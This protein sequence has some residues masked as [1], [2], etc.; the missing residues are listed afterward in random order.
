MLG[1][2]TTVQ[3]GRLQYSRRSSPCTNHA[4]LVPEFVMFR[5][6]TAFAA[7]SEGYLAVGHRSYA[8]KARSYVTMASLSKFAP[9]SQVARRRGGGHGP[10]LPR[11]AADG[12]PEPEAAG[13]AGQQARGPAQGHGGG[14]AQDRGVGAL[15]PAQGPGGDRPPCGP[16]REPPQGGQ[17]SRGRR[18]RRRHRLAPPRGPDR[19]RGQARRRLRDPHQPGTG[20]H[21]DGGRGRCV[22]VARGRGARVP[23]REDRPAHPS[24]LRLL[25]RPREGARVHVHARAPRGMAHAPA[26]RADAVRGRRPRGRPGAAQLAGREGR[27][28]GEREGKGRHEAD[29]RRAAGPRLPHPARRP[30]HA[31]AERRL[32][33][34]TARQPVP[35]RHGADRTAGEGVR[36]ARR[37]PGCL[38][39]RDSLY[40]AETP[41]TLGQNRLSGQ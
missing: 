6:P 39:K 8:A 13:G 30:R 33:S 7:K 12:L 3:P 41:V 24:C 28:L 38:H 35:D 27:G 25:G 21:G 10:G 2:A 19:R 11:R 1:R 22:Q 37:G 5:L 14:A 16:G 17:A 32:P 40:P 31:D 18:R 26:P 15:G 9:C 29:P 4:A 36:A 34:G 20:G 23:E